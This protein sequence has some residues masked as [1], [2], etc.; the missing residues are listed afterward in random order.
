M[1]TIALLIGMLTLSV[2]L[3][4]RIYVATRRKYLT[5]FLTIGILSIIS[6][7]LSV[8]GGSF[9][10]LFAGGHV[11]AVGAVIT[12]FFDEVMVAGLVALIVRWAWDYVHTPT[13]DELAKAQLNDPNIE[14][15]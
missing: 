10:L 8:I 12:Q 13:V 2:P 9:G 11:N 7:V 1:I 15:F 3:G 4:R 5:S 6:M 14:N